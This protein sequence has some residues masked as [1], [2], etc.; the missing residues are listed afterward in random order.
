MLCQQGKAQTISTTTTTEEGKEVERVV[1]MDPMGLK[2]KKRF[3][4]HSESMV[5]AEMENTAS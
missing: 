1:T 2:E 4:F 3:A 5:S